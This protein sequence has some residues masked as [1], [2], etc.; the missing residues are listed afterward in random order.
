M[1]LGIKP[2]AGPG[3]YS[4]ESL[5]GEGSPFTVTIGNNTYERGA[6]A[7]TYKIAADGSGS[8]AFDKF[9]SGADTAPRAA[10]E[11]SRSDRKCQG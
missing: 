4:E 6:G 7:A 2:F 3:S 1:G 8:F 5:Y 11:S 9:E 10:Y